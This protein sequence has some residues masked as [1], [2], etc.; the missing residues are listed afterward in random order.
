MKLKRILAGLAFGS[1]LVGCGGPEVDEATAA[2]TLVTN[3]Q[4]LCEGWAN[5]ARKCS[6]KCTSTSSW[7]TLTSDIP[8]NGCQDRADSICGRHAYGA[9]WSM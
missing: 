5:G 9:C 8:Q 7:I 1:L 3:E 6:F 4:G 2:D